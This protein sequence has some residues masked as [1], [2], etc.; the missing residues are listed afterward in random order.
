MLKRAQVTC[1]WA[2]L[3]FV[4]SFCGGLGITDVWH[5]FS[6]FALSDY[7]FAYVKVKPV[8]NVSLK[9]KHLGVMEA[10]RTAPSRRGRGGREDSLSPLNTNIWACSRNKSI[11]II[12][13]LHSF[14]QQRLQPAVSSHFNTVAPLPA[15]L[16]WR[17]L[18]TLRDCVFAE[19]KGGNKSHR[20]CFI[21]D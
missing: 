13:I 16:S 21:I 10:E 8:L 5:T 4:F 9:E 15:F 18:F 12:N 20:C 17:T 1:S 6:L 3:S 7:I 2:L 19:K 11:F 14:F